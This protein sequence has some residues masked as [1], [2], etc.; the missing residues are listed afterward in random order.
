MS[1]KV[2]AYDLYEKFNFNY[3]I[4]SCMLYNMYLESVCAIS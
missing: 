3:Q 1:L 2:I 4:E